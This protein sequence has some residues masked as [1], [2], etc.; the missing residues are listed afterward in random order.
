MR[1]ILKGCLAAMAIAWIGGAAAQDSLTDPSAILDEKASRILAKLNT[2][3]DE[4]AR[5]PEL[6]QA[7]VREDLLPVL[8]VHYSSRLILGRAGRSATE[9][10]LERFSKAMSDLLVDRYSTGLLQFRSEEQLEVLPTKGDLNPRMTRVRTRVR[11]ESGGFAPVDYVCR[12]TDDGW[13]AFDLV[14]E[15][16]SYVTTY[17][18][19]I[20]PEVYAQG[21][22]AV[23]DRLTTGD[24][25]LEE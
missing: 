16:I 22:D 5:N 4:Y 21:L 15:G 13:K 14:V 24:L 3:R 17:R 6:L 8:D 10:Q 2:N 1:L 19:Q 18:N 25:V 23:I 7:I 11:L 9:E 20:M 12:M